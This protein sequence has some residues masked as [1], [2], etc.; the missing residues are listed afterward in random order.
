MICGPAWKGESNW[1]AA[2]LAADDVFS[3][4]G[5]GTGE[6]AMKSHRLNIRG[7]SSGA[8]FTPSLI[9][10]M[11]FCNNNPVVIQSAIVSFSRVI[12]MN[13]EAGADYCPGRTHIIGD[14]VPEPVS[15]HLL[16]MIL[17]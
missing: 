16:E 8:K 15:K 14:K 10:K 9:D 3:A 17:R 1:K 5:K 4:Y 6:H 7:C 11:M 2:P 12:L 13:S